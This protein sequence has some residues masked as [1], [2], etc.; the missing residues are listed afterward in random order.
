M[1]VLVALGAATAWAAFGPEHVVGRSYRITIQ[2]RGCANPSAVQV[3]GG[4]WESDDPAPA[5]WGEGPEAGTFT[6]VAA[7]EAVFASAADGARVRYHE[8]A[9][10]F[11]QMPCHVP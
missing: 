8:L 1:A 6:I 10:E 5:S 9:T 7:H 11:S 3:A 2:R 4:G